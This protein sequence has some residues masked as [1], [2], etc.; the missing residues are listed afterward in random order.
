MSIYPDFR[1]TATELL[2]EFQQ[3]AIALVQLAAPTP[4]SPAWQPGT[5]T[6]TSR[7]LVGTVTGVP[8]KYVD[9]KRVLA[10]DLF[11]VAAVLEGVTP[12][13]E[14]KIT[15]DSKTHQIISLLPVP[16]VGTAV[17]WRFIVRS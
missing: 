17:V 15:L 4:G 5:R 6:P 1:E 13:L 14:D 7:T 12:S 16:A 2:T 10:S 9:G 11:L 8:A 3:G